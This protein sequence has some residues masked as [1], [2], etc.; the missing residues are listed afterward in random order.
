ME[1]KQPQYTIIYFLL[2]AFS[3]SWICWLSIVFCN[4]YFN[5]LWYGEPLFWI[6]YTIGSLGPA[7]SAYITYS[8][9]KEKFAQ[10][11]FIKYIF[12]KQISRK[13]GILF[14]LFLLWRLG[15][16]WYSFGINKHVSLLS[17]LINLPFLIYVNIFLNNILFFK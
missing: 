4:K 10:E 3:I 15:M 13:T 11:T 12:G 1:Q 6:L 2:C 7:I 5:A 17:F 14:A 9:F 16:I 8:R